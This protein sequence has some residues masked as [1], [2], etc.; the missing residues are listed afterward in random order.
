MPQQFY[1][2]LDAR[3]AKIIHVANAANLDEAPNLGQVE[4]QIDANVAE[5]EAK[6]DP[7]PQYL[8]AD[9]V[10]LT[11][12]ELV[13]VETA[14]ILE[15]QTVVYR[16][17]TGTYSPGLLESEAIEVHVGPEPPLSKADLWVDTDEP[18]PP[19]SAQAGSLRFVNSTGDKMHGSLQMEAD[20]T[21]PLEPVTLQQFDAA[22][23][24][25]APEGMD[26]V[27]IGNDPSTDT[28][29]ELWIDTNEDYASQGKTVSA[30]PGNLSTTGSDGLIYT[31]QAY[32]DQLVTV[33]T[34]PPGETIPARDGLLWIQVPAV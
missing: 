15:G 12:D 8:L 14:G 1:S 2:G 34:D 18:D 22:L 19:G 11:L 23:A 28:G 3:S 13:D 20:A 6:P 17:A 16:E 29:I 24:G 5:H 30:D 33:S 4:E 32:V 31:P 25:F 27:H 10:L 26:E 7:H 9:E 21:L